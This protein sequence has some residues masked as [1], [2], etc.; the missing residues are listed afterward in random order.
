VAVNIVQSAEC[1]DKKI[2]IRIADPL[3]SNASKGK[4]D[5]KFRFDRLKVPELG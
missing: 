5:K 3:K 1:R 2:K 4:P